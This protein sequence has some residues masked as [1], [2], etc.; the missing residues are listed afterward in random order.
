MDVSSVPFLHARKLKQCGAVPARILRVLERILFQHLLDDPRLSHCMVEKLFIYAMGRDVVAVD[1]GFL[2]QI[3][4]EFLG[5]D[6]RF[7]A[8][9]TAIVTSDA[10]RM[11]RGE[12]D[13]GTTQEGAQP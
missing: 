2:E 13:N 10:F 3:E 4:D 9:V 8:L 1:E 5:A 11:R 7:A 6:R 12:A